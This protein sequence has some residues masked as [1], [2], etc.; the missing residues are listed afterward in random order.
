MRLDSYIILLMAL[1]LFSCKKAEDRS[2]FKS[3]G[4]DSEQTISISGNIDSLFLYD[5]IIYNLIPDTVEKVVLKG[6][7]NLLN[8]ATVAFENNGLTIENKNRCNFLRSY[9]KKI[10]A[11]IHFN[12]IRYL[13]FQGSE[14]LTAIDTLKSGEFRAIIR[15]GAGSVDLTVDQGYTSVVI[16]HGYG[17]FTLRGKSTITF[18]NCFTNSFCDATTH[19]TSERIIASSNTQADMKI[20]A[21]G[22]RLDATIQRAG[23]IICHGEPSELNLEINGDGGLIIK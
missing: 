3:A 5:N 13:Y 16:T 8:F 21:D 9:Q 11:N 14:P 15:D 20:N 4:D 1:F 10:T 19:I 18:L 12:Q 6:G 22:I 7:E 23:N 2:C 17:D